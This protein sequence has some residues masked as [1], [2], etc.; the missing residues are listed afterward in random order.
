MES[1]VIGVKYRIPSVMNRV[2]LN[3]RNLMKIF[4]AFIINL[5]KKY[6]LFF[7]GLSIKQH[8]P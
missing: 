8:A 5:Y 2:K 6:D 3:Q 7:F 1:V 4:L